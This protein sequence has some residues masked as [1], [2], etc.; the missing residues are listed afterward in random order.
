VAVDRDLRPADALLA[1]GLATTGVGY[2]RRPTPCAAGAGTSIGADP[3]GLAVLDAQSVA[4]AR[5]GDCAPRAG[6]F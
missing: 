1:A 2:A 4:W 5:E 6:G 3:R